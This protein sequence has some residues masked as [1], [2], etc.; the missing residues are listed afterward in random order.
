M[1][2][3]RGRRVRKSRLVDCIVVV[4]LAGR[5]LEEVGWMFVA[6]RELWGRVVEDAFVAPAG[7]VG[8]VMDG[9]TPSG[10][11]RRTTL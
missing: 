10:L 1:V 6:G 11:S 9:D 4:G 3:A 8:I 5:M 7:L 2:V